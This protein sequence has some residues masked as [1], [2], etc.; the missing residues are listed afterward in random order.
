ME[1]SK[2]I[3]ENKIESED[4]IH[5][6]VRIESNNNNNTENNTNNTSNQN[7]NNN[8][9][10]ITTTTIIRVGP[11][12]FFPLPSQTSRQRNNNS[13]ISSNIP[14]SFSPFSP[15]PFINSDEIR[16]T[17]AQ[18][19]MGVE[20][21]IDFGNYNEFKESNI[22]KEEYDMNCFDLDKRVLEKGQWVDAKDTIDK[23]LEAQVVEISEDKKK[24]KI[25]YNHWGNRWD[26]WLEMNNPRIM[27]FRY[28]TRQNSLS[29][30]NSPSPNQKPDAGITLL[31]FENINKDCS[32]H[33]Y[34]P[35]FQ[36]ENI[37]NIN[38]NAQTNDENHI[39]KNLGVN[40]FVGIFNEIEKINKVISGLSSSLLAEHNNIDNSNEKNIKENQ[41]K[42]YFDLKRLIPLLDRT[43][44]IYSDVA[45]FFDHAIRNNNFNLISKNLFHDKNNIHDDIKFFSFEERRKVTQE[46][47]GKFSDREKQGG[48]LNFIS[49]IN[50]L[51]AKLI[52]HFPINDTPVMIGRKDVNI[53]NYL[54]TTN[55]SNNIQT[56]KFNFEFK[57]NNIININDKKEINE[58]KLDENKENEENNK[59][60]GNKTK[61]DKN[62]LKDFDDENENDKNKKKK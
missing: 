43:G 45:T 38:N 42:F 15:R 16:E 23:W 57:N 54:N 7:S 19:L 37:N 36:N 61:R 3:Q 24:V 9:P 51:D 59:I 48:T 28:H 8:I 4:V 62:D 13:E 27:P 53:N 20:N 40:G 1:N 55:R 17:I 46:I 31:S 58:E 30:Y 52:N 32:I 60:I 18:N 12:F 6:L 44:R 41:K 35:F 29:N 22:I 11:P 33:H 50:Q 39:L 14:N 5:L 47:L 56:E 49:P 2:S 34:N 10:N 21:L 26:E 25:H